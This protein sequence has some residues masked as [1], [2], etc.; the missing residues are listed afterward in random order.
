MPNLLK[1]RLKQNGAKECLNSSSEVVE[2]EVKSETLCF[3]QNL[4][5]KSET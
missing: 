5:Q 4:K 2:D 3:D 1:I